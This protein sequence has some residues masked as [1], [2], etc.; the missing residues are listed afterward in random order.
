MDFYLKYSRK[1]IYIYIIYLCN[2][3]Y[4][5]V[6]LQQQRNEE[7]VNSRESG[8]NFPQH[9]ICYYFT[10]SRKKTVN[11]Y[12]PVDFTVTLDTKTVTCCLI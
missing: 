5:C 4:R 12:V 2:Y 6:N 3:F 1:G 7:N 8:T 10:K 9:R 11:P